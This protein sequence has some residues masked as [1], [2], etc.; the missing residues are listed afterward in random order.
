MFGHSFYHDTI[1]KYVILF[2]TIF[3]EIFINRPDVAKFPDTGIDRIFTIKVPITYGPKDKMLARVEGDLNLD[4]PAIV[5][6][7]MA[8]ELTNIN[9]ASE[10]KLNTL[11]KYVSIDET[12]KNK[13]KYQYV[14]VPYDFNFTLSIAVKNADDGTK[15][16]EQI[17][18]FF[19]PSWNST[20][21][22]VPEM[23][24]KLDIPII[25]NSVDSQD[26]Y[27]GD[28]VTRRALIWTLNFTLK[29][30]VFGPVKS[31]EIIKIA[32]TNFF[33]STTYENINDSVSNL[34]SVSTVT[35]K[36]GLLPNNIPTSVDSFLNVPLDDINANND[37]GFIIQ[38]N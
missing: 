12:D 30:F 26:T 38:K 3:N 14:Q 33:D 13:L 9:Y 25:L 31:S 21:E 35:V 20:V 17:L 23:N 28:F 36:P 24:I 27:E 16:L 6:P 1:K 7:R 11:Q 5:L 22:L 37:Y 19:T 10:R 4:R 29:G 2:G 8:F 32:N 15:I 34:D 18:P